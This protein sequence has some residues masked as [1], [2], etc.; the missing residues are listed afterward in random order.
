Q[1]AFFLQL[2]YRWA[3]PL[4]VTSRLLHWLLSQSIFLIRYDIRNRSG[5]VIPTG[6]ACLCAFSTI[7]RHPVSYTPTDHCSLAI[8]GAYR[9]HSDDIDTHTLSW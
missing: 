8:S 4:T 5:T 1:N 9:P 3:I 6:A 2:P 7:P